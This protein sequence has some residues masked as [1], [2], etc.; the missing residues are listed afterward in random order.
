MLPSRVRTHSWLVALGCVALFVP[1]GFGAVDTDWA[2]LIDATWG[3]SQW[4][5]AQRTQIFD[6]FWDQVDTKNACFQDLATDWN[7]IRTRYRAEAVEPYISEGRFYAIMSHM[8]MALREGHAHVSYPLVS[9]TPIRPGLPLFDA[10]IWGPTRAGQAT[11]PLPDGT[12]LIYQ[13]ADSNPLGLQPGDIILGYEGRPWADLARELLEVH[14]LPITWHQFGSSDLS[15][16]HVLFGSA[17]RNWHLFDTMDVLKHSTGEVLHLATAPLAG[18]TTLD[19]REE[20]PIPGIPVPTGNPG[21]AVAW[22]IIP[23]TNIGYINVVAWNDG[24]GADFAQAI[25]DLTQSTSTDGLIIDFR[26][27]YGGNM[28]ESNNGLALLFDATVPTID[29]VKRCGNV[30]NH[31]SLCSEK[32][33]QQY[34]IPGDPATSYHQPIAV[35]TG[36][37]AISSGDQ[38]ALRF[39]FHPRARWFG[40]STSTTFN[41]PSLSIPIWT[42]SQVNSAWLG[43]YCTEDAYL[44]SNPGE[45]LTHDRQAVDCPVW[46]E[47]DDVAQGLDTV[48]KAAIG[49]IEGTQP[50]LDGDGIPGPCDNCPAVANLG[51]A[52]SDV[53]GAGDSCDCAPGNPAVFPGAIERND[54]VDNQCPGDMGFGVADETGGPAG[55]LNRSDSNEYFWMGQLDATEYQVARSTSPNFSTGCVLFTTTTTSFLDTQEPPLGTVFY[56]LNRSSSPFTGSWGQD[57]SGAARSITCM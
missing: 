14:E 51:Q 5:Q 53:D 50:D 57:S 20:L 7:A 47:P 9:H 35:L 56:Y 30:H 46:L 24:S 17:G 45:Y 13:V 48:L 55:F 12:A 42:D 16:N 18:Q 28:F 49:W 19:A 10:T 41:D 26:V 23:G 2:A 32:S 27:N 3:P 34:D 31:L 38:V 54:G 39:K 15:F 43:L 33:S 1:Y 6:E 40:K 36:P 52:D 8:A 25:I 21:D 4:T 37:G 29:F 11:T 22:G 44:L